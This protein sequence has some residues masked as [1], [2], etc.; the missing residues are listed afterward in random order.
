MPM[1]R[2][3]ATQPNGQCQG[4]PSEEKQSR[5]GAEVEYGHK[6]SRPID[7]LGKRFV[8]LEVAH[9]WSS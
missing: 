7:G 3:P 6:S 4:F 9:D 5:N 1:P 2:L 8:T